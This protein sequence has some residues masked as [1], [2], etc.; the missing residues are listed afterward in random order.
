[1]AHIL[2]CVWLLPISSMCFLKCNIQII[3]LQKEETHIDPLAIS[4]CILAWGPQTYHHRPFIMPPA[5]PRESHFFGSEIPSLFCAFGGLLCIAKKVHRGH[6]AVWG[7]RQLAPFQ[8]HPQVRK[9]ES[10]A[11]GRPCAQGAHTPEGPV[12]RHLAAH[13]ISRMSSQR[14][15]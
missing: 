11:L 8:C 12:C 4:V 15:S 14:A 10:A 6:T 1:M 7:L 5:W 13:S 3:L 2:S 9:V